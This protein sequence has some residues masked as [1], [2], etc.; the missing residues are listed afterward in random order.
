M[1]TPSDIIPYLRE[2]PPFDRLP[3][4]ELAT[5]VKDLQVEYFRQGETI[6]S[7]ANDQL[8]DV[9]LIRSGAVNLLSSSGE[10]LERRGEGQ[11]FGHIIHFDGETCAYTAVT[12]EDSLIWRLAGERIG[13]LGAAHPRFKRLLQAP[14]GER[15]RNQAVNLGTVRRIADL[16]LRTPVTASPDASIRECARLMT[17]H[18][19]S[20]LPLLR[21]DD[22]IGIITDRDL[23]SRVIAEALDYEQPVSTV[24]T[25]QPVSINLAHSLEEALVE[26]LRH[27]IHHLPVTNSQRRLCGVVSAGDLLRTQAPH[28]LRLVRD[29]N[30]ADS[31]D[32]VLRLGQ[33]GPELLAKLSADVKNVSQT[34][35]IAGLITDACTRRLLQLSEAELGPPPMAY[36]WLAFGSQ[37]RLEQGLTSDQDNGLLLASE[38][39]EQA[40]SY[41]EQLS[42]R[43]CD[44][45]NGCGYRYCDGGVMAMGRWRYSFDRWRETFQQWINEPDPKSVMHT[46]IFYDLRPI[47]G[48]IAMAE[49]L[50]AG[51]L[52]DARRNRIFLRFLAAEALTHRPPLGFFRKFVQERGGDH[53]SGL[54]LKQRGVIPVVDLARVLALEGGLAA[55]HTEERLRA[56]ADNGLVNESD[57]KNLIE[58]MRFIGRVRLEHQ[59]RQTAAGET[60]D[61][62]VDPASL[63][64]LHQRYLRAAFEVV[65]SSQQALA[66]RYLLG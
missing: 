26:L 29:L 41:F 42:R 40:A 10:T 60:P 58:A 24:M 47:Y 65:R 37:A 15:L 3:A 11:L 50:R 44:G 39:D 1:A 54:N 30:R 56:A 38:P 43:V 55:V 23:R 48:D 2:I 62:Y 7:F 33:Q 51:V 13:K 53:S 9:Y 64:P 49:N 20:C 52:L 12:S 34:G 5:A 59:A 22:L 8:G 27:G 63:S 28:P 57:A 35:R 66:Q 6:A 61:H 36:T 17:E 45:L 31:V 16:P 14:P 4:A 25:S 21:D 19:A 18:R 46:S 32:E